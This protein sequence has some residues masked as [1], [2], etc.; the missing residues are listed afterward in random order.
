MEKTIQSWR[1]C[2][3]FFHHLITLFTRERNS[4]ENVSPICLVVFK[5]ITN[6]DIIRTYA[7]S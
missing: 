6:S 1:R 2:L 5:L 7:K 3:V 4:G